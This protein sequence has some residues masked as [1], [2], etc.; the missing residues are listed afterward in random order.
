M[1]KRILIP[2]LL[3]VSTAAHAS[4][5][6][7]STLGTQPVFSSTMGSL[8]ST[9][10]TN[11]ANGVLWTDDEQN[12]FYNPAQLNDYK[13]SIILQRGPEGGA[14][15]SFKER[16][17]LGVYV[18][19]GGL[20]L[21]NGPYSGGAMRQYSPGLI[22]PGIREI[23]GPGGYATYTGERT[24]NFMSTQAPV[25][26]FFASDWGMKLGAS[27][28]YAHGPVLNRGTAE[29]R[30]DY[31]HTNIGGQIFGFEPFMGWTF[32]S[33]VKTIKPQAEAGFQGEQTLDEY[34]FGLRFRY[35]GWAPYFA[36]KRFAM[37]GTPMTNDAVTS[38]KQITT[39]MNLFGFGLGHENEIIPGLKLIK[40]LGAYAAKVSDNDQRLP[41]AV[42]PRI[43]R[44]YTQ[45]T[46]PLNLAVEHQT[47]DWLTL[48]AGLAQNLLNIADY[49]ND[50]PDAATAKSNLKV[51]PPEVRVGGTVKY[52]EWSADVAVG[53]GTTVRNAL[54]DNGGNGRDSEFFGTLSASYKWQT[55]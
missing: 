40:H 5:A 31:W 23:G 38:P 29:K 49:G 50:Q 37:S 22:A 15:T 39:R 3:V 7:V 52:K 19:R 9:V 47:L 51:M 2:I 27:L 35:E 4:V 54:A 13:N 8:D 43:Y 55:W 14:F 44:G 28:T 1:Q 32:A 18:N 25:D 20:S 36:Y 41:D 16:M 48:R 42:F 46:I 34:N 53:N 33:K 21:P 17:S 10:T 24:G 12:I 11:L 26:L 45:Y 6:R 30:A